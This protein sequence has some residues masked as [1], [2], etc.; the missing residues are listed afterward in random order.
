MDVR[1]YDRW[2]NIEIDKYVKLL[3]GFL[4][5]EV[6]LLCYD[7]YNKQYGN[8]RIDLNRDTVYTLVNVCVVGISVRRTDV[9][10]HFIYEN[11]GCLIL[12]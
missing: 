8:P 7:N 1:T 4:D 3:Q 5:E 10:M 9:A 12:T 6:I 11:G 2:R